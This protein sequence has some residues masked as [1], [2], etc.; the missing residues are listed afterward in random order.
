MNKLI[1]NGSKNMNQ[2]KEQR[3]AIKMSNKFKK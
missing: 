3:F 1:L 2:T